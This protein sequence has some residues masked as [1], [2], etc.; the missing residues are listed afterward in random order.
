ML[1]LPPPLSAY[2]SSNLPLPC[3]CETFPPPF[4][5]EIRLFSLLTP[6]GSPCLERFYFSRLSSPVWFGVRQLP[7]PFSWRFPPPMPRDAAF[8]RCWM[9]PLFFAYRS[10]PP[11]INPPPLTVCLPH[12]IT[13]DFLFL[14]V[15]TFVSRLSFSFER[16]KH[17]PSPA[18]FP[19]FCSHLVFYGLP[20]FFST[21]PV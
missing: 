13:T 21:P 5:E 7:L 10:P 16:I 11:R 12:R 20:V 6:S 17:S 18:H 15:K 1:N 4:H 2:K 19:F 9:P 14:N 3:F 8:P